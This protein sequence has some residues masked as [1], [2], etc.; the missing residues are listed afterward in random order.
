MGSEGNTSSEDGGNDA[1]SEI[2]Q[3]LTLTSPVSPKAAAL[4]YFLGLSVSPEGRSMIINTCG[5]AVINSILILTFAD[6][7]AAVVHSCLK[8]LINLTTDDEL[9][10]CLLNLPSHQELPKRLLKVVIDKEHV[11]ADTVA[12]ILCNL[13]RSLRSSQRMAE[14]ILQASDSSDP[15]EVSMHNLVLALS[16]ENYNQFAK[17]HRLAPFFSNLTQVKSIRRYVMDKERCVIQRLIP[18][19]NYSSS[20]DRRGGVIGVIRNCCFDVNEHNWLLSEEVDLLPRLLLPLA[21]PEELDEDDNEKLPDDLQYLPDDK[22][23]EEDPDLRAM[24]VETVFKLC[25]TQKCREYIR[26]KNA[27]VILREL[28]KWEKDKKVE[29]AIQKLID[30][31]IGD[32]EGKDLECVEIPDKVK[33]DLIKQDEDDRKWMEEEEEAEMEPIC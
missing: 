1:I 29:L 12:A 13:T 10:W 26:S 3:F 20:V 15:G 5:G 4:E 2:L 30:L 33:A 27:Y 7:A 22:T 18:F 24:L 17:L 21:G 8:I 6:K 9:T 14:V 31:L 23:R 11:F 28:H 32:D 16:T 19:V 25:S